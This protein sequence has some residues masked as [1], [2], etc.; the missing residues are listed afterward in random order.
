LI[1]DIFHSR[2]YPKLLC[3]FVVLTIFSSAISSPV[4]VIGQTDDELAQTAE[5]CDNHF[6]DDGDELVDSQD[7]DCIASSEEEQQSSDG[8]GEEQQSS[9]GGGVQEEQ[10]AEEICDNGVDDNG[11]GLVDSMDGL[12]SASVGQ[13]Q[14]A[15]SQSEQPILKEQSPE[16]ICDNGVDD[17]GDGVVDGQHEGCGSKSHQEEEQPQG[18][19]GQ[20]CTDNATDCITT[21]ELPA[22]NPQCPDNGNATDCRTLN[23]T[24]VASAGN[25]QEVSANESVSLNGLGSY[26]P[27]GI[28]MSFHWIQT[29]GQPS[30]KLQD[31]DTT[32]PSFIAPIVS[33]ESLLTFE[34]TVEDDKGL[35]DTDSVNISVNASSSSDGTSQI[36]DLLQI[37]PYDKMLGASLV[38][39]ENGKA[40][41]VKLLSYSVNGT[42]INVGKLDNEVDFSI[43]NSAKVKLVPT[44]SSTQLQATEMTLLTEDGSTKYLNKSED[45]WE[46]DSSN[47]ANSLIIDAKYSPGGGAA[48]YGANVQVTQKETLPPI[49]DAG[50]DQVVEGNN[51]VK[52]DGTKSSDPDGVITSYQ[53]IQI[54]GEPFI[55]VGGI[56]TPNPTFISP[57]NLGKDSNL[58]YRLIVTDNSGLNGTDDVS[59]LIKNTTL[60]KAEGTIFLEPIPETMSGGQFYAFKGVLNLSFIPDGSYVQIRN[61]KGE[62]TDELLTVGVVGSDGNFAARWTAIPHEEMLNIYASYMDNSG[63]VFKSTTYPL[64]VT[65][66]NPN[67]ALLQQTYAAATS[68]LNICN[69]RPCIENVFNDWNRNSLN[70]YVVADPASQKYVGTAKNAVENLEEILQH[71][72]G[73]FNAWNL[74]VFPFNGFPPPLDLVQNVPNIW[75]DLTSFDDKIACGY[76]YPAY[77][78]SG[79]F[80]FNQVFTNPRCSELVEYATKHEL[81]HSLGIGHTWNE[82]NM[83]YKTNDMLC[84]VYLKNMQET[85]NKDKDE[86]V[87]SGVPTLF[88]IRAII[89]AYGNNGFQVPNN[90]TIEKQVSIFEQLDP[91]KNVKYFCKPLPCQPPTN[92]YQ[93]DIKKPPSRDN[94]DRYQGGADSSKG[95][96]GSSNTKNDKADTGVKTKFDTQVKKTNRDDNTESVSSTF[97]PYRYNKLGVSLEHPADWKFA[98]LKNGFQ[99]IR[100]KNGVYVEIRTHN[101]E[102]SSTK[103]KQYVFDDIKERSTERQDF[104]VHNITQT[105]ISG[106]L[107]AY[108][109]EYAFLKTEDQKDFTSNGTTNKIL[110]FWTFA[111]GNAYTVAYVSQSQDYDS[112]L[113]IALKIID[114]LKINPVSQQSFSDNDSKDKNND[115]NGKKKDNDSN[116][117]DNNEY[118]DKDGDGDIDCDD[119]DKKNFKV[120]PG[121]P[122]NLDGDG[123]GIGCEG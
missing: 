66:V 92:N 44:N 18:N 64:K 74:N 82:G 5:I 53:W 109:T 94:N 11:N 91:T 59:I 89:N 36:S 2:V 8:G 42:E 37:H 54:G 93:S 58:T 1:F 101:L 98:S 75:I 51:T 70:V 13:V 14:P 100:E 63:N 40:F 48:H 15:K 28:I 27:D 60:P 106:N 35:T 97:Q 22:E 31:S 78:I 115:S 68:T 99:L 96:Q 34:L 85:C 84:S 33:N 95:N 116:G 52:L 123:D 104:E 38:D 32:Q 107:P 67:P 61:G 41:A 71:K 21:G 57:S 45:Q 16:E 39:G 72:T 3:V 30:V 9:D 47:G 25:M 114:T 49:A 83:K 69:Q 81:I 108:K 88:D 6:D 111:N 73:N 117:K 4:N 62:Q 119:V 19:D 103:L 23:R 29:A 113:P 46:F 121:D 10:I 120:E 50:E 65:G 122:G 105:T 90:K 87:D 112:Y 118:K 26:D 86:Y 77:R 80:I 43:N 56:D 55:S 102:S 24:P 76:D 7:E 12:C 110:R 79:L 20:S 17:N